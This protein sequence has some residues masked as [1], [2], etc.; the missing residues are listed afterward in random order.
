MNNSEKNILLVDDSPN[1]IQLI[2][3][4]LHSQGY[5]ISFAFNGKDAIEMVSTSKFDLILLDIMMPEMDGFKVFELLNQNQLLSQDRALLKEGRAEKSLEDNLED[6][7]A[8]SDIQKI[9]PVIFLTAQTDNKSIIKAFS[10]GAVDYIKKPFELSEVLARVKTQLELADSKEILV[11]MNHK[12]LKEIALRKENEHKLKESEAIYRRLV[13]SVPAIVYAFSKERGRTFSSKKVKDILGYSAEDFKKQ[14]LLWRKSVHPDDKERYLKALYGSFDGNHFDIKYRIK[15][16]DGDWHWLLDRSFGT[17]T[18]FEDGA[19]CIEGIAIEITEQVKMEQ[20]VL[21]LVKLESAGMFAGGIAHDMNNLNCIVAGNIELAKD[22]LAGNE[23]TLGLLNDAFDAVQKQ[24]KLIGQ[25][26]TLTEGFQPKKKAGDIELFVRDSISQ[27]EKRLK[28][29]VE[30]SVEN[31]LPT[32]E[33]DTTMLKSALEN[34]L[35]NADESMPSVGVIKVFVKK[36]DSVKDIN[37][38]QLIAGNYVVIS[39]QDQGVGI[40]ENEVNL[41]FDPYYSK[42][43]RG[44]QKGMGLGLTLALAMVKKHN[45]YIFATSKEGAGSQFDIYLPSN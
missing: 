31:G 40:P 9:P 5:N 12:L 24:T 1:N 13:E 37:G 25:L 41:I 21:K 17:H 8:P 28:S 16:A 34:I 2:G 23:A 22:D 4:A 7:L 14:P 45:G 36:S 15:G 38:L 29:D 26:V 6:N 10:L 44:I 42:K 43:H 33:F 32:V 18:H 11:K 39:V 27:I 30:L 19:K 35:I 20:E 3:G